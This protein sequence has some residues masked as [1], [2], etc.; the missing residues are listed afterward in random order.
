L[1]NE[2]AKRQK[3]YKRSLYSPY[4]RQNHRPTDSKEDFDSLPKSNSLRQGRSKE[5]NNIM[6]S[7]DGFIN[8]KKRR[9]EIQKGQEE[10]LSSRRNQS[11]NRDD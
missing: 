10:R 3:K 11:E 5:R 6:R 4:G 2:R 9:S 8:E 1:R 7:S